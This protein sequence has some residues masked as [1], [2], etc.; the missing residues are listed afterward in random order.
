MP[1]IAIVG[2]GQ[3]GMQ[4]ADSLRRGGY[5]GDVTLIGEEPWLPY[6]RP[7]LSKQFLLGQLDAS[8]VFFRP[9]THYEKIGVRVRLACRVTAIDRAARRLRLGDGEEISFDG[10]ALT[11]GARVRKLELPGANDSRICYLR[12]LSD[13]EEIRARLVEADRVVIVGGGF[14]GLE[15]AA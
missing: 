9:A 3:A 2:A 14:I 10:L 1:H 6:Q 7:P 5:T 13:A 4:L 12:G 15:I 8:R 11:T